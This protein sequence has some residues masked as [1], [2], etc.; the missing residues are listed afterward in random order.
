MHTGTLKAKK[1]LRQIY[2]Y[3]V[4]TSIMSAANLNSHNIT[5]HDKGKIFTISLL[6]LDSQL[7]LLQTLLIC[8]CIQKVN[9][10]SCKHYIYHVYSTFFINLCAAYL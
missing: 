8:A 6:P 2:M 1:H 5:E 7:K 4:T 9:I 10:S 3:P